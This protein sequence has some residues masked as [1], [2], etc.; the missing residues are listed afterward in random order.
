M[1]HEGSPIQGTYGTLHATAPSAVRSALA[2]AA[3]NEAGVGKTG[4]VIRLTEPDASPIFAHVLPLSSDLR[5]RLQP[6]AV[7]AVFIAV[8]PDPQD[9]ADAAAAAFGLTQGET[10]VLA[11]LFARRTLADACR[12]KS[13]A[14]RCR[15]T[16]TSC[17]TQIFAC[18]VDHWG[19]IWYEDPLDAQTKCRTLPI[20][21]RTSA[22]ASMWIY[23]PKM[24]SISM[25]C[26]ISPRK[27]SKSSVFH[28]GT[29]RSC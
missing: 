7:A 10:R 16:L 1:L 8:P 17:F 26:L 29:E 27:N 19:R 6:A 14:R 3:R 4:L 28:L 9:G 24:I 13:F 23:L 25:S 18:R 11:S 12:P 21:W 2:L 22:L 20:G 15:R 5:T